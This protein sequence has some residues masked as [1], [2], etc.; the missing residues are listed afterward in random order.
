M[1]SN[2]F[3]LMSDDYLIATAL[4]RDSLTDLERELVKRLEAALHKSLLM[5]NVD[6]PIEDKLA[7]WTASQEIIT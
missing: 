1:N 2:V 4:Q 3:S 7:Y 5:N 6:S